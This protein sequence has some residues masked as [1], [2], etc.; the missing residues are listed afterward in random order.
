MTKSISKRTSRFGKAA[1]VAVAATALTAGLAGSANASIM[2]PQ[3]WNATTFQNKYMPRFDYDGNSCFPAA[4]VDSSGRLNG[5][6][7]NTGTITGGCRNGHLGKANTYSQSMCKNGWCAYVYTLYFEKDQ[8]LN[9]ADAF[10]HRHDW[11]TVVVFQKQGEE[12]PRYLA[13]SRH[14]GYSTHP[15]NE[16]PMDGNHVKI[17]YHKDGAGTHA[18]RFAKWSE[19]PEAHSDGGWDTPAL[20]TMEYMAKTPRDALWSSNIKDHEK[21]GS[22]NFPLTNNLVG[23]INKARPSAVPAF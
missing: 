9:G 8:T 6:L 17:V 15:I 16:V 19:V 18:F 13:A 22:A 21:W 2:Q 7:D 1:L 11:E 14:K 23:N 4:A 20:V 10:G 3:G 12:R 5:G